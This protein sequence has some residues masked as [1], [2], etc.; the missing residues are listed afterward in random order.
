MTQP[1]S[2]FTGAMIYLDTLSFY[3]LVRKLHP[4]V[5]DLFTRIKDGKVQAYT[6]ALTFDELA[7]R[8]VSALAHERDVKLGRAYPTAQQS[9]LLTEFYPQ[10]LPTL[11]LLRNFPNLTLLDVSAI[12]L[13]LMGENMARCHLGPREALHLAAMQKSGCFDIVSHNVVFDSIPEVHRYTL[14]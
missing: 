1:L 2:A 12:D 9:P 8:V 6:S 5:R 14:D 7:H 13:M 11:T 4:A 10:I 3:A